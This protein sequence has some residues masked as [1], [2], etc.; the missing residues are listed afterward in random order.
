MNI[1]GGSVASIVSIKVKVPHRPE[2][3]GNL[4]LLKKASGKGICQEFALIEFQNKRPHPLDAALITE[5]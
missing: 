1:V 3:E 2:I 4:V 5:N